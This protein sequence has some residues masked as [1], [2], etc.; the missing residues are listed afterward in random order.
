MN[1]YTYIASSGNGTIA[2]SP[3]SNTLNIVTSG[4][5]SLVTNTATN[6]IS[7][8]LSTTNFNVQNFTV[9]SSLILNPTSASTLDNIT[10]GNLTPAA[11]TFTNLSA[12]QS[13]TLN[14]ANG[15]VT[16]S[17]TGTGTV[18]I[19]PAVTGNMDNMIIGATT[20]VA[21]TFTSVSIAGTQQTSYNSVVTK[22]YIA[23]LSAAYGVALS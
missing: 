5:L 22:G 15:N 23:A 6:T 4:A 8:N 14:P 16:I 7:L 3:N 1:G 21:G 18:T 2:L 9:T 10:I 20:P 12:T 17:P 13:V 19:N 11:G